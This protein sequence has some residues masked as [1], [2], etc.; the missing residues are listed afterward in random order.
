[1]M[2]HRFGFWTHKHAARMRT[3]TTGCGNDNL[4]EMTQLN[5]LLHHVDPA[6]NRHNAEIRVRGERDKLV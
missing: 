2:T 1:M 4:G 6:D 3:E 5:T